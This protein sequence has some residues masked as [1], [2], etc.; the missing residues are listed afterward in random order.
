MDLSLVL[1]RKNDYKREVKS[2]SCVCDL[3][4]LCLLCFGTGT[5]ISERGLS[6]LKTLG[7]VNIPFH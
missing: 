4:E 6:D 7:M 2:I 3:D 5:C 1:M